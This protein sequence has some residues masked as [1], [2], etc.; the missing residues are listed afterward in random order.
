MG[1]YWR[2]IRKI[3]YISGLVR[4]GFA[5]LAVFFPIDEETSASPSGCFLTR[6]R[7]PQLRR[8]A[9]TYSS[10]ILASQDRIVL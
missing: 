4:V 3:L 1:S 2:R 6:L 9:C 10:E 8:V 7:C 5:P